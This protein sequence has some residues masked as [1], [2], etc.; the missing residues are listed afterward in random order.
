MA[1]SPLT[2]S[3]QE[4]QQDVNPAAVEKPEPKSISRRELDEMIWRMWKDEG[5]EPDKISNKLCAQGY[6]YGSGTVRSRLLAQ[7][8]KL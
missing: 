8:A 4:S 2:N 6:F 7:G 3:L 5:L 1:G